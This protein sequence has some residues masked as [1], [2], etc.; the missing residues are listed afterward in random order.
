MTHHRSWIGRHQ[1]KIAHRR[2][3]GLKSVGWTLLA[4][5]SM[6]LSGCGSTPPCSVSGTVSFEGQPIENGSLKFEPIG[7]SDSPGGRS[8]I[9][10]G[11]YNIPADQGMLPG[12]YRVIFYATKATG[13]TITNLEVMPGES[14]QPREETVQFLPPKLNTES[15]IEAEFKAGEN[16]KDFALTP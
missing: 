9:T 10:G 16:S 12:K 6:A 7:V 4:F 14:A 1:S 2:K 11:K 5:A 13:K 15:T 8:L 3:S